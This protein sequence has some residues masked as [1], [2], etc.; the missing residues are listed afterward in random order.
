M[1]EPEATLTLRPKKGKA[2]LMILVCLVFVVGGIFMGIS[3]EWI[4]FLCAAFFALGIPIG[5]IQLLP[6][7]T[8]LT[9]TTEGLTFCNLFRETKIPW[10]VIDHFF[11]VELRTNGTKTYSMVALNFVES[12][13]GSGL[14][15]DI[16]KS[17]AQC[18]GA[19]PD[20]YGKKPQE[21]ADLLNEC[22][23]K[24]RGEC[25]P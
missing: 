10:N 8:Y 25:S 16:S 7:S 22:L 14:G 21:L 18:D 23:E 20:T 3:G 4:G 6:G 9:L 19:L 5:V 1:I 17:L 13:D 24:T 15:R 12:Y 2:A 11:V